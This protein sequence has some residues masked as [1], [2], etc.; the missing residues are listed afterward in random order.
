MIP[1]SNNQAERDIRMTTVQQKISGC[2]RAFDGANIFAR[3]RSYIS[4]S[5][6]HELSA[7]DALKTLFAGRL[8]DFVLQQGL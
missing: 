8:P 6:K 4:T 7:T 3:I 1:F 5:L 2:F